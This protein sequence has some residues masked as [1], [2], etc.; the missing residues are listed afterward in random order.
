MDNLILPRHCVSQI[1]E[2]FAEYKHTPGDY[3]QMVA[4][5]YDIL[6]PYVDYMVDVVLLKRYDRRHTRYFLDAMS[7]I[8][9]AIVIDDDEIADLVQKTEQYHSLNSI[10]SDAYIIFHYVI[11]AYAKIKDNQVPFNAFFVKRMWLGLRDYFRR[12]YF[13]FEKISR[14]TELIDASYEDNIDEYYKEDISGLFD[15]E[16]PYYRPFTR[17]DR[18]LLFMR[19]YNEM[20]WRDIRKKMSLPVRTFR[21]H[22]EALINRFQKLIS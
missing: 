21:S 11:I 9:G 22:Q 6:K 13:Y 19:F 17:M 8:N 14:E 16:N 10:Y 15:Y 3:N 2:L 12:Q 1:D 4:R 7:I 5:A 20:P 18:Y